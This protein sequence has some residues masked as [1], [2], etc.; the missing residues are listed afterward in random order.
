MKV[1]WSEV[2]HVGG[3]TNAADETLSVDHKVFIV[4][5]DRE[6]MFIVYDIE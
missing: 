5:I 4:F 3:C 2:E 6:E 1:A